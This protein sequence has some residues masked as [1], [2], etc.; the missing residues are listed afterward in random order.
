MKQE[1]H[2]VGAFIPANDDCNGWDDKEM[3]Q[4]IITDNSQQWQ[5]KIKSSFNSP[6]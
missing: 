6:F 5:K 3:V 1:N 4:I 2:Q